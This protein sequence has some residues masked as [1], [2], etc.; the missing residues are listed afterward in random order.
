MALHQAG[1]IEAELR[2]AYEV[3]AESGSE[4]ALERFNALRRHF[5]RE[6]G[7]EASLDDMESSPGRGNAV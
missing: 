7:G 1:V 3:Y 2:A 4:E 5:R 6:T